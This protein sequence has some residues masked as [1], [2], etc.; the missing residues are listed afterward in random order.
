MVEVLTGSNSFALQQALN[1]RVLAFKLAH[2]DIAFEQLDASESTSK[3]IIETVQA[4]PFLSTKRL[5]ILRGV[6]ENREVADTID[7]ICSAVDDATDLLIVEPKFDRRSVLYKYLTK[8]SAFTEYV[9]MDDISLIDWLVEEATRRGATLSTRD[10]KILINR[11]GHEQLRL[12]H[13]LE[14]LENYSPKITSETIRLLTDQSVQSS[15]FDLLDAAL[16]KD[17]VTALHLY[18]EQR[19]QRVEPQAIMGLLAW[20]LHIL[21]ILAT[22]GDRSATVIASEAKLNPYVVRKST[23]IAKQLGRKSI[24]RLVHLLKDIDSASKSVA[25]DVDDALRQF[26]VSV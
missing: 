23:P 12:S 2:G 20:Q 4:L 26:I 14:K 16:R 25:L 17:T 18:D 22:A 8:N 13:E 10:A 21:A 24:I 19:M 7:K 11:V 3:Q 6:S 15:T 9:E 5:V 1:K